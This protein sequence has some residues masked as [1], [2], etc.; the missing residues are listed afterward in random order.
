MSLELDAENVEILLL[1]G[2]AALSGFEIDH[3]GKDSTSNKDRIIVHA[4]PREVE[5]PG[6]GQNEAKVWRIPVE[7]T[8]N[9]TT[10]TASGLDTVIA[11]IQAAN[12]GTPAAAAV[13]AA[14]TA[15]PNGCQIDDTDDGES[16]HTDNQRIH[17]KVFNFIIVV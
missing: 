15:F 11:A 4:M 14:T 16:D 13:T 5:L 10:R 8:V 1:Q 12:T 2:Q 17:R 7:I 3:F 6:K 9:Y